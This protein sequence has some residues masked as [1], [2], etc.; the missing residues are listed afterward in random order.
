MFIPPHSAEDERWHGSSLCE[1]FIK[2]SSAIDSVHSVQDLESFLQQT[3]KSLHNTSVALWCDLS[4][5]LSNTARLDDAHDAVFPAMED[6]I[7]Q[8]PTNFTVM[9]KS[10]LYIQECRLLK[11][12]SEAALLSRAADISTM[13]FKRVMQRTQP[14]ATERQIAA[15]L[16]YESVDQGADRLAF[17]P[18]CASGSR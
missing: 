14:G 15:L 4:S 2:A 13:A 12:S 17:P 18:V 10:S 16:E 11:S 6:F 5:R 8:K 1:S 9:G 3:A 7:V